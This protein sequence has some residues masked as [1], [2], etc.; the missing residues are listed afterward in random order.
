MNKFLHKKGH[1]DHVLAT[2]CLSC[3]ADTIVR[4]IAKRQPSPLFWEKYHHGHT[5]LH[6][7]SQ[8]PVITGPVMQEILKEA[9]INKDA[10][11]WMKPACTGQTVLHMA[12]RQH[13]LSLISW[14][15]DQGCVSSL[16]HKQKDPLMCF[17]IESSSPYLQERTIKRFIEA[18]CDAFAITPS[19][20]NKNF[21]SYYRDLYTEGYVD[22]P[23]IDMLLRLE[24]YA[25]KHAITQPLGTGNMPARRLK[26]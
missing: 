13:N 22:Q 15:I 10:I 23:M 2:T 14:L 19:Y 18:G 21:F 12:S 26:M 11:D 6:L 25:S 5:P 17:N 20:E 7:L 4:H 3:Q 16:D 1:Q 24:A 9:N 8:N